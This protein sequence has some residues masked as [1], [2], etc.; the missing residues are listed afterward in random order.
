MSVMRW[1]NWP[2]AFCVS[3]TA[4]VQSLKSTVKRKSQLPKAVIQPPMHAHDS[5]LP[6]LTITIT[7][8]KCRNVKQ[9]LWHILGTLIPQYHTTN[10]LSA[11]RK[12]FIFWIYTHSLLFWKK[13]VHEPPVTWAVEV[14]GWS[15]PTSVEPAQHEPLPLPTNKTEQTHAEHLLNK[16]CSKSCE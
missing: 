3:L 12:T 4:C 2:S 15:E 7:K 9:Y 5:P 6:Y 14:E 13:Y 8:I 11:N 16:H 1:L 10:P